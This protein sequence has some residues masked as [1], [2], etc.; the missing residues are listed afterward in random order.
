DFSA[1]ELDL[2]EVIAQN[3]E[4]RL[5][6]AEA[7]KARDA[8]RDDATTPGTIACVSGLLVNLV[9]QRARLI[10]PCRADQRHPDGFKTYVDCRF[11]GVPGLAAAMQGWFSR[12]PLQVEEL[13]SVRVTPEL[14]VRTLDDGFAVGGVDQVQV[15]DP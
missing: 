14:A 2:V 6:K 10:T 15:R 8:R 5:I 9:E 13:P 3:S 12:L 7:G 1:A 4:S 11:D